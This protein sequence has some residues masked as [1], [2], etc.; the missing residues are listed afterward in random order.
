MFE[1]IASKVNEQLEQQGVPVPEVA[2]A[3]PAAPPSDNG[4]DNDSANL[5]AKARAE[6]E[7]LKHER[8][9]ARAQHEQELTDLRVKNAL[10]ESNKPAEA[11]HNGQ[12]NAL[13]TQLIGTFT[14][15]K[16]HAKSV[17]ERCALQGVPDSA[18]VKDAD[19]KRVFGPG[20]SQA[21]TQLAKS[22]PQTYR[23][24]RIIAIERKIL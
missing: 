19:L 23:K 3:A 2:P 12:A 18:S 20:S 13:R 9:V 15:A 21:A 8:E 6:I 5:L 17:E 24:W 14:N 1:N 4:D 11:L 10:R 7:A 16:W 22:D